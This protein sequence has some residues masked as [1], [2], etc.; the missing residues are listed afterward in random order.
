MMRNNSTAIIF[1][2]LE[3][4]L[5]HTISYCPCVETAVWGFL[6]DNP[7]IGYLRNILGVVGHVYTH[8][9]LIEALTN[10]L[11]DHELMRKQRALEKAGRKL[12]WNPTSGP[13]GT[14]FNLTGHWYLQQMREASTTKWWSWQRAKPQA[15]RFP[16]MPDVDKFKALSRV[17]RVLEWISWAGEI[18]GF[19]EQVPVRKRLQD[20]ISQTDAD[21]NSSIR[22]LRGL[23]RVIAEV[24][25]SLAPLQLTDGRPRRG[26]PLRGC[27]D[28]CDGKRSGLRKA[29]MCDS[30]LSNTPLGPT[31]VS[32][33]P[34]SGS[35]R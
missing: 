19:A 25:E 13:E 35:K 32:P 10:P 17:A 7:S 6:L 22:S 28:D 23:K 2:V 14:I 12:H 26:R 30:C 4:L 18:Y 5:T 1:T 16:D 34:I 20:A 31:P 29:I 15:I 27:Q 21:T 33:P 9:E 11:P 8:A 24:R 3:F